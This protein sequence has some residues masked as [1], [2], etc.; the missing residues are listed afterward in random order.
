MYPTLETSR[1]ERHPAPV[2][3]QRLCNASIA[4]SPN[5][6]QVQNITINAYLANFINRLYLLIFLF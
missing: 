1:E 6:C 3:V 5:Y 4:N 2:R